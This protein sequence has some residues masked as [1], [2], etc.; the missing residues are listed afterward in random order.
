M[1]SVE[2]LT[3]PD[4]SALERWFEHV[5]G[6]LS[7]ET[8][9]AVEEAEERRLIIAKMPPAH[10]R[11]VTAFGRW[12]D[13]HHGEAAPCRHVVEHSSDAVCTSCGR[14]FDRSRDLRRALAWTRERLGLPPRRT[15]SLRDRGLIG[16]RHGGAVTVAKPSTKAPRAS[17]PS[18]D[19]A[20]A[21]D[22]AATWRAV[23]GEPLPSF[24]VI[25]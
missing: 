4:G 18:F 16:Q 2:D 8:T 11:A 1:V 6:L 14:V 5:V 19:E 17:H 3:G 21:I 22:L 10:R 13:G 23:F 12:R 15:K 9:A 7:R 25:R 20:R 24:E